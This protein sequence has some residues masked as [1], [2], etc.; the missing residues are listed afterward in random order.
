MMK[1]ILIKSDFLLI[2]FLE[3]LYSPYKNIIVIFWI[4][5]CKM[6]YYILK[7]ITD[8]YFD[9]FRESEGINYVL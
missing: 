9:E 2:I 5:F 7:C 6:K 3:K 4:F 1:I 8:K